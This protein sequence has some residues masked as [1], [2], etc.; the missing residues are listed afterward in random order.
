MNKINIS[1]LRYIEDLDERNAELTRLGLPHPS[2]I[3]MFFKWTPR[4]IKIYR[5]LGYIVC[6]GTEKI[7]NCRIY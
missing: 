2:F 6:D 4:L 7:T 3:E 5:K 1:K